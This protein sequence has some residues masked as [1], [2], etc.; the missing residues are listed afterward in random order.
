ML[1]AHVGRMRTVM[2]DEAC[3]DSRIGWRHALVDP[4]HRQE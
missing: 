1:A 2:P 3:D 4:T